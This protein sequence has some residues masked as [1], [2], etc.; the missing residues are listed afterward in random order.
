[1]VCTYNGKDP[2][3]SFINRFYHFLHL[4][5]DRKMENEKEFES[6]CVKIE[7]CSVSKVPL[8]Q[9]A[10]CKRSLSASTTSST[11]SASSSSTSCV[12]DKQ[13]AHKVSPLYYVHI[14]TELHILVNTIM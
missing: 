7:E 3:D 14:P 2:L 11:S 4:H 6:L 12:N 9:K 1:M 5:R 13:R 10:V 8:V